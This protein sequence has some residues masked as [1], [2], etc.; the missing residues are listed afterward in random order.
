M[1]ENFL[2]VKSAYKRL[3]V[4]F[5]ALLIFSLLSIS[6]LVAFVTDNQNQRAIDA[7]THLANS[8]IQS[9][10]EDLGVTA[11]DNGFWDQAVE[12]VVYKLNLE[13]ADE[14]FG[15]YMHEN[16]DIYSTYVVNAKNEA[17]FSARGGQRATHNLYEEYSGGLTTLIERARAGNSTPEPTPAIGFIRD[18][19]CI[20]FAAALRLTNYYQKNGELVVESTDSVLILTQKFDDEYLANIERSFFFHDLKIAKKETAYGVASLPI[21]GV[22]G[23]G[24][25]TMVWKPTLPGSEVLPTLLIGI[26][27]IFVLMATTA[28]IFLGRVS[29]VASQLAQAKEDADYANKAKSEFLANMSHELR[30]PMNAILGF[31][32]AL[33][34]EVYGKLP[35]DKCRESVE[36]INNAGH[37]LLE[38]INEILD[39]TKIEAGQF[40]LKVEE[41]KFNETVQE[42]MKFVK[43]WATERD[44]KL[45]VILDETNPSI[46]SD[47]KA[48]RQIILNLV[49]NAIKFTPDGGTVSCTSSVSSDG[50]ITFQVIDNGIGIKTKDIPKVMEPFSQVATSEA[51]GHS[52]TGLGLP[53]T[54]N[55]TELL[56]GTLSIESEI[57]VGTQVT[58]NLP[59]QKKPS[60]DE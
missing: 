31:S 2:D 44:V 38:L 32:D 42:T 7:S 21:M 55:L 20:F 36:D 5:W 23:T 12:N 25:G 50:T 8:V 26:F 52:G 4:P 60:T 49:T 57:D 27:G 19:D 58:V 9:N 39:L 45:D 59:K 17:V 46:F 33:K 37:H 48:V 3:S 40:E 28:Y 1:T 56:G 18:K 16:L 41:F 51:R 34:Q 14:N 22:D 10:L 53:I 15:R 11:V 29:S 6:G 24:L 30:T 43:N 35:N 54:K 47:A 13:W